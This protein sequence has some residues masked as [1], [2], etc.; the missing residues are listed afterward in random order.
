MH[1]VGFRP[2]SHDQKAKQPLERT[3]YSHAFEAISDHGG[4]VWQRHTAWA[5]APALF[6]LFVVRFS[7]DGTV[8]EQCT[9]LDR[10]DLIALRQPVCAIFDLAQRE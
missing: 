8:V 1:G 2:S 7:C 3:N 10:D 4:V 5:L 9:L 6:R